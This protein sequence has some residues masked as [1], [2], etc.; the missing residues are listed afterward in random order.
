VRTGCGK[1]GEESTEVEV[2]EVKLGAAVGVCRIDPLAAAKEPVSSI[3]VFKSSQ[4]KISNILRDEYSGFTSG[5]IAFFFA[6]F[7]AH[8]ETRGVY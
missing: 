2:V 6:R 8:S 7:L 1:G 4:Q 3:A 5:Y